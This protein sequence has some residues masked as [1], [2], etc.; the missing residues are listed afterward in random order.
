MRYGDPAHRFGN[1]ARHDFTAEVNG[2]LNKEFVKFREISWNSV[3]FSFKEFRIT[4]N[5]SWPS[6][7]KLLFF[8]MFQ[9][10]R[11]FL[12]S[13]RKLL[14]VEGM[15]WGVLGGRSVVT[16]F[17]FAVSTFEKILLKYFTFIFF[18]ELRTMYIICVITD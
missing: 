4:L 12:L 18:F 6:F 15:G 10:R 7:L 9:H 11:Y 8:P 2:V 13:H 16:W 5:P 3:T 14:Q 17:L 1:V